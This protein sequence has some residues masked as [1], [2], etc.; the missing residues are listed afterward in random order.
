MQFVISILLSNILIPLFFFKINDLE[1]SNKSFLHAFLLR[2]VLSVCLTVL[3]SIFRLNFLSYILEPIYGLS[4]SY[5]FIRTQSN[6][7]CIFYGLFPVTLHNVIFRSFT[8]FVL[9]FLGQAE[10]YV[11]N[12]F[13]YFILE[14]ATFTIT[15]L[16]FGFLDYNFNHFKEKNIDKEDFRLILFFNLIMTIYFIIMQYLTFLQYEENIRSIEYRE[17]LLVSYLF[18][19]LG[20]TKKLDSHL[21]TKLQTELLFQQNVHQKNLENYSLHM[22]ELYREVKGFRHDYTNLL[23]TLKMGIEAGDLAQIERV[24]HSVLKDTE[25]RVR[26]SHFDFGRLVNIQEPALKSLLAAKFSEARDKGL[27]M[28]LEFPE[29]I[30]PKG[31]KLVDLISI[32]SILVDNA[33]DESTS[34]I[35]IAFFEKGNS[36][37]LIV[38]NSI[39]E[40]EKDLKSIF[41]FGYS[42]KGEARG[43]GLYNLSR[44][45]GQLSNVF[46]KTS[47][48]NYIFRQIVEIH[49]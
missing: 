22:E 3:E 9:P 29:P 18:I 27:E 44:T 15:I 14:V 30:Q 28:H 23:T 6:N 4:L 39:K 42:T 33:I 16:F 32:I 41:D 38:E 10:G 13:T 24:Y 25:N 20:M 31:I 12:D 35:S 46:L 34:D 40:E 19:F 8:F 2:I 21:N 37:V 11:S 26:D 43:I 48:N 17:L 45:V 47:S 49:K 1:Y 36:Q 5:Y 7:L